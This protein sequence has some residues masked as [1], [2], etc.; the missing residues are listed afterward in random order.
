LKGVDIWIYLHEIE[1][2]EVKGEKENG[3]ILWTSFAF[4]KV[5]TYN[6]G[7]WYVFYH[8]FLAR[9]FSI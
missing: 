1:G 4:N 8:Y 2:Y 6:Q 9:L 7:Y 3:R 5:F